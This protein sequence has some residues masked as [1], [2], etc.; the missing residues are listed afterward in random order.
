MRRWRSLGYARI[1]SDE[2]FPLVSIVRPPLIHRYLA[3]MLTSGART[4]SSVADASFSTIRRT[5]VCYCADPAQ[6][7]V[8]DAR[9]LL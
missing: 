6:P 4:S 8:G 5:I 1:A 9:H 2:D 3:D 7:N